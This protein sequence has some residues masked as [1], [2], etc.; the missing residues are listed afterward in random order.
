MG[1]KLF[2]YLINNKTLKQQ[3]NCATDLVEVTV[4]FGIQIL[5]NDVSGYSIH[6][7]KCHIKVH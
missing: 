3:I 5:F 1:I 6:Q 4:S 2:G 7:I